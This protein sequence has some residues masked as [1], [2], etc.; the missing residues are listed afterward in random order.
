[1][2]N[3]CQVRVETRFSMLLRSLLVLGI[4]FKQGTDERWGSYKG[5]LNV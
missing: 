4:F 5:S 2:G 1:M 3:Y